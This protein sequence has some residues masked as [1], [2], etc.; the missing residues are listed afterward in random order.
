[1][2]L[3]YTVRFI[4]LVASVLELCLPLR[5][6][7][8]NFPPPNPGG[9][10]R[11]GI[12]P[13]TATL[14]PFPLILTLGT[15][16]GGTC[17]LDGDGDDISAGN[18]SSS[19]AVT[20]TAGTVFSDANGNVTQTAPLTFQVTE[21]RA[22]FPVELMGTITFTKFDSATGTVSGTVSITGGSGADEYLAQSGFIELTSNGGGFISPTIPAPEPAP[23]WLLGPPMLFLVQR[24]RSQWRDKV[25]RQR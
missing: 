2:S 15:C 22:P 23:V 4:A 24:A 16:T 6:D 13:I 8:I 9:M 21:L 12:G 11:L 19:L 14:F 18:I 25:R 10:P 3:K 7:T 20:S 1:M 17:L 5:A